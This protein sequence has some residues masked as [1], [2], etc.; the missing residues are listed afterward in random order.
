MAK[1]LY[2]LTFCA[3]FC[4]H[5]TNAINI[6]LTVLGKLDKSIYTREGQMRGRSADPDHRPAAAGAHL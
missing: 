3:I 2:F 6:T 1:F 5:S 4:L